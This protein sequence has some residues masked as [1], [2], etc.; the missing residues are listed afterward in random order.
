MLR[1]K[2][3]PFENVIAAGTAVLPRLPIGMMYNAITLKLGGT[4]LTKAMLTA[5][6]LYLNGK[7]FWNVSGSE[8]DTINKFRSLT[9]NAAYLSLWFS[10]PRMQSNVERQI[11]AIDTS[12]GVDQFSMEVDIT[13]A[14]APTLAAWARLSPPSP[15]G[16]RF[17]RAIRSM[18]KITQTPGAAGEYS[19]PV[20][21]GSRAGAFIQANYFFH[22]NATKL[23]V[24]RDG[25]NL[26]QEGETGLLNFE[27]GEIDEQRTAQA[28]LVVY[29]PLHG[30]DAA[31]DMIPT[32]RRDGTPAAF[33]Y[34][35][36]LS[37]ADT[38][39]AVSD[40]ITTID[41]V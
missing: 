29:D 1:H 39:K 30:S 9:D 3:P 36:T 27:D 14:T 16:D 11:G 31:E 24:L 7:M 4:S 28:G 17:A 15:K 6:R 5:I 8:I 32:V 23:Q 2:L 38:V 19:L 12:Q 34:K 18:L 41:R 35:L 26:L 37:A 22:A 10:N 25:L 13:G 21:L 20:P 33:E 40:L